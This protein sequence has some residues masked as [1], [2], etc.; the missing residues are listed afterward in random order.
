MT[1]CLAVFEDHEDVTQ[2]IP[3]TAQAKGHTHVHGISEKKKKTF[4]QY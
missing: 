3:S 4:V 1:G 2:C